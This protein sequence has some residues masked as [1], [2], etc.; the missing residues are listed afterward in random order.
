MFKWIM[1]YLEETANR[2]GFIARFLSGSTAMALSMLGMGRLAVAGGGP[3]CC[4]L[5]LNKQTCSANP[6]CPGGK[7][8]WVCPSGS[9]SF[10]RI[11]QCLECFGVNNGCSQFPCREAG[12][13]CDSCSNVICNHAINTGMPC[14]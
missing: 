9:G 10:C 2:R 3:G 8:C 13:F 6:N 14:F 5:C 4:A 11:F 12:V 7:W 1:R